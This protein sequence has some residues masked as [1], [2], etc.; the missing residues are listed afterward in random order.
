MIIIY[1]LELWKGILSHPKGQEPLCQNF[2]VADLTIEQVKLAGVPP[3]V[4][5]P[6]FSALL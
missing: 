5:S 2:V 4:D 1:S 3:E 6:L